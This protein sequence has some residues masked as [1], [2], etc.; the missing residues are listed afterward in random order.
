MPTYTFIGEQ[1]MIFGDLHYGKGASV[2][3]VTDREGE[4]IVLTSGDILSTSEPITHAFLIAHEEGTIDRGE[5][6][7]KKS[8]ST[9]GDVSPS[10][11]AEPTPE[12][13]PAT[14]A[15]AITKEA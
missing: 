12:E 15:E 2:E 11:D 3:G 9:K 14:A 1:S 4:A 6:P 5:Q 7:T 8:K 13:S 10:S